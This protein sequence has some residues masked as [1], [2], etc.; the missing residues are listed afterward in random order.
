LIG[1]LE[2]IG[3]TK[4]SSAV[5]GAVLY[6]GRAAKYGSEALDKTAKLG[7]FDQSFIVKMITDFFVLLL[8]VGILELGIRFFLVLYDFYGTQ[9]EITQ[10]AADRLAADIRK[11]MVNRGGPVAAR[12]LYPILTENHNARGLEIAIAPSQKTIDSIKQ[13]F[14]FTPRGIPSD[15]SQ[16]RHHE[17]SIIIRAEQFCLRCHTKAKV[18]DPL[19]TITV[20]SYLSES[21]TLWWTEVRLSGVLGLFKIVVD[22]VLLFFLLRIRMEP[23]LTLR[24]VVSRL[25]RAG[26]DLSLRAP[27]K[28]TDEFGELASD[29][30]QFL[31]RLNLILGDLGTV[32]EQVAA[33]NKRLKTV[34][35]QSRDGLQEISKGLAEATRSL[36]AAKRSEPLLSREWLETVKAVRAGA[37]DVL[38]ASAQNRKLLKPLDH[39]FDQL[40]DA[41]NAARRLQSG[42]DQ[43]GKSLAGLSEDVRAFSHFI[44]EMAVLEEKMQAISVAGRDLIERLVEPDED[45]DGRRDKSPA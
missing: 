26:N 40:E 19:G 10:V 17:V 25:S 12:T 32:L 34:R 3:F 9:A 7:R 24:S 33:L 37:K 27:I 22:T 23:L 8:V 14:D 21:L 42:V 36:F 2:A 39:I 35:S 43:S 31:D 6:I 4:E 16:G 30:N 38:G 20:R 5:S 28:S 13:R 18:G 11:I 1:R 29:L 15:W 45:N 41:G 44:G